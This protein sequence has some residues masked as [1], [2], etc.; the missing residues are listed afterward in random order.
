MTRTW[1]IA[2]GFDPS[3]N[4]SITVQIGQDVYELP[5]VSYEFNEIEEYGEAYYGLIAI[6]VLLE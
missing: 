6:A 5:R 3:I 1:E 4:E 2:Q